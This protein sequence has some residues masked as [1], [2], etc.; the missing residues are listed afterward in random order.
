[1]LTGAE[2]AGLIVAVFWAILVA[3]IALTLLKLSRLLGEASKVVSDIGEQAGPLLDDMNRTVQRANEQLGR[4]D[5]ITKQVAGVTQNVSAVTTVM[6]SVVGGPLVKAAAFS[7]GVRKAL[8]NTRAE[9]AAGN[10]RDDRPQLPAR[11]A[12]KGRR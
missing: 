8:G 6:T 9:G 1:M 3:F 10:G 12:G 11:A 5:V 4:T 2:L 7:Y